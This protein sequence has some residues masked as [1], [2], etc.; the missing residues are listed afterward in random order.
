[1]SHHVSPSELGRQHGPH[2][3]SGKKNS[4]PELPLHREQRQAFF[5]FCV[6]FYIFLWRQYKCHQIALGLCQL[7]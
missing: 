4:L 7:L 6:A 2:Q 3:P 1:M 5:F